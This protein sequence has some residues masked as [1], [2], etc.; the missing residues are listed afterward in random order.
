MQRKADERRRERDAATSSINA[1]VQLIALRRKAAAWGANEDEESITEFTGRWEALSNY[2]PATVVWRGVSHRS[3]EHAFQAAKAEGAPDG[4]A[5]AIRAAPTAAE[6]HALGQQ[7]ALPRDW[8][9]RRVAL[10]TALIRDKFRRDASLR[11]RLQRTERKN[12]IA[13]NGWGETF[14]GVSGGAGANQ[15]GKALMAL[16]DEVA[17][18]ADI[19]AWLRDSFAAAGATGFDVGVCGSSSA[20]ASSAASLDPLSLE[21]SKGGE[22]VMLSLIHI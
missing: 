4:A 15:L 2:F 14:W 17:A 3:V 12:L 1:E 5:A 6:A 8:E 10:M 11:E 16:R 21:V 20:A 13:T 19:D 22:V 7:V 18:G 9:R